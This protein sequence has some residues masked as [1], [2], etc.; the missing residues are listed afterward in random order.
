MRA[1]RKALRPC[2]GNPSLQGDE[3]IALA[4][5]GDVIAAGIAQLS[6]EF[7]R[8]GKGDR[9]LDRSCCADRTRIPTSMTGIDHNHGLDH[10]CHPRL[11]GWWRAERWRDV[12][13]VAVN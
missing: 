13:V 8:R 7:P 1:G 11:V 2:E 12:A 3:H 9:F 6:R 5:E 4:C 10:T